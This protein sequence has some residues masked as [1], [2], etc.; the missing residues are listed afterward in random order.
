M[1]LSPRRVIEFVG[2]PVTWL[3]VFGLITAWS[4][5]P[6]KPSED[7]QAAVTAMALT[8]AIAAAVL[9]FA[10]NLFMLWIRKMLQEHLRFTTEDV[11]SLTRSTFIYCAT[12]LVILL[13]V[14]PALHPVISAL[15]ILLG[16][17][18]AI[19]FTEVLPAL[20]GNNEQQFKLGLSRVKMLALLIVVL[21]IVAMFLAHGVG[22]AKVV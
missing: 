19:M 2:L 16:T 7:M 15:L 13:I 10:G 17:L 20:A 11:T 1:R 14:V 22:D 8:T 12:L 18:T 5:K 3:V 21:V 9:L 6:G 4:A